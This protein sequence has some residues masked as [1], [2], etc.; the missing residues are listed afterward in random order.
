MSDTIS[1]EPLGATVV[2]VG[3]RPGDLGD[4]VA[5]HGVLYGREEGMD[6]TME[7]E[8][9][10][11]LANFVLAQARDGDAAGRLWVVEAADGRLVGSIGMTATDDPDTMRLRWF[12]LDP[13][14]RGQGLGHRLLDI[15]LDHARE[16]GCRSVFLST[17]DGLASAQH[18]YRKAGFTLTESRHVRKWGIE[19]IEQRF[20]L[21]LAT[22]TE[23]NG[24]V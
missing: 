14:C 24:G 2:R 4:V 11:R 15:A 23:R 17:I 13:A 22:A 16:R 18:L 6:Q 12:L 1:R 8:V 10:E 7:A 9:A 3:D 19:T 20:D 21:S 5:L